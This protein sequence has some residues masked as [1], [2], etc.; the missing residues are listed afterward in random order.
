GNIRL[1][2]IADSQRV[3]SFADVPTLAEQGVNVQDSFVGR[4]LYGPGGVPA[5]VV[6]FLQEKLKQVAED[7]EFAADLARLNYAVHFLTGEEYLE[8]LKEQDADIKALAEAL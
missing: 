5:D 3:S 7:K 8:Y 1:L 2:G 4:G 6:A